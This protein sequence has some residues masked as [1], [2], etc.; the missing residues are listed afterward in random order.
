M[1]KKTELRITCRT[2]CIGHS[3]P[4]PSN[5]ESER[6]LKMRLTISQVKEA[7]TRPIP[8]SIIYVQC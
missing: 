5:A 7:P 6:I 3:I 4:S 8:T 1:R 2:G